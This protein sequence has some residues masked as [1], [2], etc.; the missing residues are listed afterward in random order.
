MGAFLSRIGLAK[1]AE[2]APSAVVQRLPSALDLPFDRALGQ[3]AGQK[4]CVKRALSGHLRRQIDSLVGQL[5]VSAFTLFLTCYYTL[6]HRYT[7]QDAILIANLPSG[8]R[9]TELMVL[10]SSESESFED[11][12]LRLEWSARSGELVAGCTSWFLQQDEAEQKNL[13]Q[14]SFHFAARPPQ[15]DFSQAVPSSAELFLSVIHASEDSTVHLYYDTAV[16][17]GATAARFL[18]HYENLLYSIVS[19]WSCPLRFLTLLST[20]ERKVLK[21]WNDSRVPFGPFR[22]VSRLFESR[23][24]ESPQ[25]A[26]ISFKGA[27]LSYQELNVR[28]NRLAHHLRSVGVTPGMLVGIYMSRGVEAVVCLLSVL[29]AGGAY[30]PLDSSYPKERLRFILRDA[31]CPLLLTL[32]ELDADIASTTA[33]VICVDALE[34]AIAGQSP[35]NLVGAAVGEGTALVLYT[36]GST[37][38]PKGVQVTHNNLFNYYFAW[39]LAH[40]LQLMSAIGQTSFFSFAVFQGDVMRALC[41][42]RKLV[43]CPSEA[44]KC[45]RMLFELMSREQ[46]DFAEFVP[47]LLRS[48]VDYVESA[49]KSLSFMRTVVVGSDRWYVREQKRVQKACGP[50]TKLV[51]VYGVSE[52]TFDSTYF[53]A[54]TV[55][56]KEHGLTPIGRPFPNV[57]AYILDAHLQ[58]V[59]IGVKGELCI[60]GAG[61][62]KGY[63]NRPDLTADKFVDNPFDVGKGE[64]L[65]RTGDVSRYLPD[66]NIAFLGRSDHQ[67]KVRGFRIELGEIEAHL[68]KHPAIQ[69]AIVH[70]WERESAAQLVAY[71]VVRQAL[72]TT[73]EELHRFLAEALPHFMVPGQFMEL[74]EL[75]LTPSG[76]I[77]RGALPSPLGADLAHENAL[78][79]GDETTQTIIGICGHA[80]GVP[81]LKLN[82]SLVALGLDSLGITTI[83]AGLEDS[84]DIVIEDNDLVVEMFCSANSVKEFVERKLAIH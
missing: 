28:A 50:T 80:I 49:G 5:D 82:D 2:P 63:L 72:T 6:L 32:T 35:E 51:H 24:Q 39:E 64:R 43:L 30:L 65:Y 18:A 3:S 19:G 42:G 68:E 53:V 45:P 12:A 73:G 29:K 69:A 56:L 1:R 8:L 22:P 83:V 70:P 48:L 84:F 9:P 79:A 67:V 15:S 7:G 37:G 81:K 71:Y 25:A 34:E 17:D 41:S 46:V 14:I 23:V 13:L 47:S 77:N 16:I 10:H 75:P 78:E 61:V 54:S 36:S 60:G 38:N 66:G 20:Q 26:A 58:P 40:Q 57:Q 59:P 11:L 62:A 55:E 74:E 44:L 76:K 27:R 21:E 31:H 33:R 52:T 4:L